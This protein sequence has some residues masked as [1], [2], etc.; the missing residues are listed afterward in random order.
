[1]LILVLIVLF[2]GFVFVFF[3]SVGSVSFW[4]LF[5]MVFGLCLFRLFVLLLFDGLCRYWYLINLV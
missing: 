2:G 3:L 5:W 1:M 4:I